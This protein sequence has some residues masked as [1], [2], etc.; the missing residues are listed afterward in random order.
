MDG[1]GGGSGVLVVVAVVG[2]SLVGFGGVV[3]GGWFG[4]VGFGG[5]IRGVGLNCVK[6]GER[7]GFWWCV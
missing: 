3:G 5:V 6:V 1:G 2:E 7:I 4:K